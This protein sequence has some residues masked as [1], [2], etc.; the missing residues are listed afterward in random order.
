MEIQRGK[1]A[2]FVK[3]RAKMFREIRTKAFAM[4]RSRNSNMKLANVPQ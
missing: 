2:S 1:R 3:E 4:R